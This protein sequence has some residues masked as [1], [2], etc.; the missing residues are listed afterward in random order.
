M[1]FLNRPRRLVGAGVG[2]LIIAALGVASIWFWIPFGLLKQPIADNA[3]IWAILLALLAVC[4]ICV[5]AGVALLRRTR[6]ARPL[7]MVLR[8]G[9]DLLC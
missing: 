2:W 4:S 7:S 1:L 3:R 9:R 5:T 8:C 6:W